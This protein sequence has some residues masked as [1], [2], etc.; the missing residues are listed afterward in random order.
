MTLKDMEFEM[1]SNL[2][3]KIRD[4]FNLGDYTGLVA[5]ETLN[6]DLRIN[7]VKIEDLKKYY[8]SK[9]KFKE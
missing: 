7:L 9:G 6:S 8:L 1:A 2:N 4:K 5:I 3:Q